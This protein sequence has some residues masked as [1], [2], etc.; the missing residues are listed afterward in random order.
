MKSKFILAAAA[1][2]L[3]AAAPQLTQAQDAPAARSL[4]ELLK[5][6]EQ[7]RARD[8]EELR[9]REREFESQRAEQERLLREA[10][11]RQQN[12]ERTSEQMERNFEANEREISTLNQQLNESLGELKELFGIVQLVA[13]DAASQFDNSLTS[14]QYPGRKE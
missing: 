5:L 12:L 8:S 10:R 3:V 13:G 4:D 14:I 6:V 2:L 1:A 11:Q 7:G 9:R